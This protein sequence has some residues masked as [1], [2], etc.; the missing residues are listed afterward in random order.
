MLASDSSQGFSAT[1]LVQAREIDDRQRRAV[2]GK[3]RAELEAW[4]AELESIKSR[5][6]AWLRFLAWWGFASAALAV[7]A[8]GMLPEDWLPY[9]LFVIAG[10][11]VLGGIAKLLWLW[12]GAWRRPRALRGFVVLPPS[13]PPPCDPL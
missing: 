2:L 4:A 7:L 3:E 1:P 13:L 8:L 9:I 6:P 10:G 12:V 11:A 5:R